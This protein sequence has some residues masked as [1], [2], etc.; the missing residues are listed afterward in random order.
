MGLTEVGLYG[1]TTEAEI[2]RARLDANGVE[3]LVQADNAGGTLPT[4]SVRGGVRVLVREEDLPEAMDV[5]E[6]MLPS[7]D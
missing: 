3:A 2:V 4:I 5:L 7:G 6:R 1:S